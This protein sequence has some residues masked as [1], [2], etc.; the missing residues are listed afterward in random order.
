MADRYKKSEPLDGRNSYDKLKKENESLRSEMLKAAQNLIDALAEPSKDEDLVRL[1]KLA[2]SM[3][4]T[5]RALM[6]AVKD[7]AEK[8]GTDDN[9][10]TQ[11]GS[12]G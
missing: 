6:D 5:S 9:T 1:G 12:G 10:D 8:N 4:S 7:S 2:R 3:R 11:T